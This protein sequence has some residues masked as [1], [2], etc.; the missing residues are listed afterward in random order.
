M[1]FCTIEEVD[2]TERR[3]WFQSF[4]GHLNSMF[5]MCLLAISSLP[6]LLLP[7][8]FAPNLSQPECFSE[9]R[10]LPE[11]RHSPQLKIWSFLLSSLLFYIPPKVDISRCHKA[12]K[13]KK[14]RTCLLLKAIHNLSQ[15]F[16][17]PLDLKLQKC[18]FWKSYFHLRKTLSCTAILLF[19]KLG[20]YK[21]SMF[22]EIKRQK[23]AS[24]L[25]LPFP[26]KTND[27]CI[28]KPNISLA[29]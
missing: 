3:C 18:Y 2:F 21:G 1:H 4:R 25:A 8:E 24:I 6:W 15:I 29:D 14:Q 17:H 27:V 16:Q 11:Q 26:I 5:A 9:S 22:L 7:F 10:S 28:S 23:F 12:G 13:H 19:S 20:N